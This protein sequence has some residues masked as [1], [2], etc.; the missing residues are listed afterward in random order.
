MKRRV[1]MRDNLGKK[2]RGGERRREGGRRRE[3]KRLDIF[4]LRLNLYTCTVFHF[5]QPS[6]KREPVTV[7]YSQCATH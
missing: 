7:T 1:E 2:E 6:I 3:R 5:L 4:F